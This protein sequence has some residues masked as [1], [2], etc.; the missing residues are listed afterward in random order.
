M[1]EGQV[2]RAKFCSSRPLAK[3]TMFNGVP[4]SNHAFRDMVAT[5]GSNDLT[6]EQ[7]LRLIACLGEVTFLRHAQPI[8]I[9]D[10]TNGKITASITR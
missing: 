7:G 8:N 4:R 5:G 6:N 9:L 3:Y 2:T 10:K 1:G